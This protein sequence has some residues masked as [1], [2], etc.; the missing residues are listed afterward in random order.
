MKLIIET[1]RYNEHDAI[2]AIG[3]GGLHGLHKYEDWGISVSYVNH[4]KAFDGVYYDYLDCI[5]LVMVELMKQSIPFKVE[6]PQ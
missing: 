5:G 4:E 1:N 2:E 6:Y 3:A